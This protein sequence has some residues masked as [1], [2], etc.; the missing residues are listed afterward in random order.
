MIKQSF[1]PTESRSDDEQV[2][3]E[4]EVHSDSIVCHNSKNGMSET[5]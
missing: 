3:G 4:C 2:D 1:S 5:T